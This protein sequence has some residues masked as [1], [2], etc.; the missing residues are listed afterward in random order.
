MSDDEAQIRELVSTWMKATKA[1][2]AD[3]VL[4]LMDDDARFL[5]VG[6]PPF[7]KEAFSEAARD[8][9]AAAVEFDGESEILEIQV[10][11]DWA[12]M[13]SRLKVRARQPGSEDTLRA[14]HTLTILK[15]NEGQWKLYRDANL[16]VSVDV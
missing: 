10:L 15:K 2:D 12:F 6:H 13:T 7:G 14:G 11:G 4:G 1:G 3:T 5:V 16:L 8:Q 9:Q